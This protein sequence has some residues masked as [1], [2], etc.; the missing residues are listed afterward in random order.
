MLLPIP[1]KPATSSN[2]QINRLEEAAGF[3]GGGTSSYLSGSDVFLGPRRLS[4][5]SYSNMYI[6]EAS[7]ATVQVQ[8]IPELRE[9]SRSNEASFF[10]QIYTNRKLCYKSSATRS[11]SVIS[12][13]AIQRR[14]RRRGYQAQQCI[15]TMLGNLL[16]VTDVTFKKVN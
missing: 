9:G 6:K 15:T 4:Y 11:S 1:L 10:C 7:A 3:R 12:R 8:S 16:C 2:L 5:I 14:F 13:S